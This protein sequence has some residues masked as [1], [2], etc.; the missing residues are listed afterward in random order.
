MHSTLSRERQCR[1]LCKFARKSASSTPVPITPMRIQ[2]AQ[3][4]GSRLDSR[5]P[6]REIHLTATEMATGVD[7]NPPLRVYDTAGPHTEPAGKI[8]PASPL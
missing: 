5:V 1:R 8:D 6:M 2:A 3:L 4:Q 7:E